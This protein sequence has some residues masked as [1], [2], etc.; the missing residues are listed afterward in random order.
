MLQTSGVNNT[1]FR[2]SILQF[3]EDGQRITFNIEVYDPLDGIGIA[4]WDPRGQI[5]QLNV[6]VKAQK[7]MIYRVATRIGPPYFSYNETARELNLTGNALYQG[8]A[9]DLIDAIARHVGFE[10]VFVPVADQQYGKLDK[11]TKQWNG[12]IGEIIN[13]VSGKDEC[14]G[15]NINCFLRMHTWESAT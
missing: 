7:K 4:I 2:T 6:D 12:I 14:S 9:V 5:T 3:D 8:Y 1:N 11:E 10:Y 15:C 13:N